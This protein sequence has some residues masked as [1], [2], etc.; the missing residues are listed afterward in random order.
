MKKSGRGNRK[1]CAI[2]GTHRG[3]KTDPV[4][5]NPAGPEA[6][7]QIMVMDC[8]VSFM[9]TFSGNVR[10]PRKSLMKYE[11]VAH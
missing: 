10:Q 9:P 1:H 6:I 5:V 2:S 8:G 7:G 11:R 4:N 3:I